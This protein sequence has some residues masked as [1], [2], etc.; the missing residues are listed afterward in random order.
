M[1]STPDLVV[2]QFY[3]TTPCRFFFSRTGCLKQNNCFFAHGPTEQLVRPD[4][5]KTKLCNAWLQNVCPL[6]TGSCP[7]AHGWQDKR[8]TSA[9]AARGALAPEGGGQR[10][11]SDQGLLGLCGAG[12][13]AND[14]QT[15]SPKTHRARKARVRRNARSLAELGLMASG[16]PMVLV[17]PPV[18]AT[19]A[20]HQRTPPP[21]L[22]GHAMESGYPTVSV[23]PVNANRVVHQRTSP[24]ALSALLPR[25]S[26]EDEPPTPP[27]THQHMPCDA[28]LGSSVDVPSG[29]Q[30]V[31]LDATRAV[32][33]RTPLAMPL[34]TL[35]GCTFPPT[36][37]MSGPPACAV[38]NCKQG[39]E[40]TMEQL[41]A[42][43]LEAATP[44]FYE[45]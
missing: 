45:D 9:F 22:A 27:F 32:H 2:E 35:Y 14:T 36:N 39:T 25:T 12:A 17:P 20:V 40:A 44:E 16:D 7:F 8:Q 30:L 13:G 19:R 38:E 1:S 34:M 6:D 37:T 23:A 4:L 33:H 31:P 28:K 15:T 29:W 5:T 18:D 41:L 3:K 42:V 21:S 26:S 43:L 24:S 10:L 11:Q